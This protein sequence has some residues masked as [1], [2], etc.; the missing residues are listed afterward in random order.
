MPDVVEIGLD[1]IQKQDGRQHQKQETDGPQAGRIVGECF[2]P[3]EHFVLAGG[4]KVGEE[5]LLGAPLQP[6][7]GVIQIVRCSNGCL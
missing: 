4:E 7:E 6:L 1:G 3:G 2:H 5:K